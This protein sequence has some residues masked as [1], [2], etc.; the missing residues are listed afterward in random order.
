VTPHAPLDEETLAA[1]PR[2]GG[3]ARSSPRPA[4]PVPPLIR[5]QLIAVQPSDAQVIVPWRDRPRR[6]V[7][8]V[9]AAGAAAIILT[10]GAL[11][12]WSL[13]R[14]GAAA[15]GVEFTDQDGYIVAEVT[16]PTA[17][18]E[19]LRAAFAEHGLDIDLRLVPVSLSLVGTVVFVGDD[20]ADGIETLQG[21][22]CVTGG[23]GAR[24]ACGSRPSTRAM[25][26]LLLAAEP[27]RVSSSFR[28][29]TASARER[30]SIAARCSGPPLIGRSRFW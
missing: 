12:G 21:G 18:S 8:S 6:R 4:R 26:K 30:L 9:V 2:L 20:G 11:V 7:A 10:L 28:W 29:R 14:P 19:Q 3:H 5:G 15:A 17:A 1:H 13:I 25:R 22:K 23:G 16:D 24:S 27:S